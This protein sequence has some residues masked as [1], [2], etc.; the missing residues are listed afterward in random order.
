MN[1]KTTTEVRARFQEIV[2]RV[3]Y[4]KS[5]LIISKNGKPWVMVQ[6]L[7]EDDRDLQTLVQHK[8]KRALKKEA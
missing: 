8:P 6:P 2:D 5:P 1:I 4:T 7:P 3:H